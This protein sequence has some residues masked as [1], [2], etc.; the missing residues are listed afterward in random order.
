MN[1]RHIWIEQGE[2]IVLLR[3]TMGVKAGYIAE[4]LKT[5]R[6]NYSKMEYGYLNNIRALS[7]IRVLY[8][9]WVAN[10]ILIMNERI[11]KLKQ[12]IK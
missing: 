1:E 9:A 11:L 7:I 5:D 12:L 10:E 8:K 3:K 4:C 2:E 6:G